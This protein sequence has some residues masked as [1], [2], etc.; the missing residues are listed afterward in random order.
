MFFDCQVD[1][2]FC[3]AF[4]GGGIIMLPQITTITNAAK[5]IVIASGMMPTDLSDNSISIILS[6]Q[7]KGNNNNENLWF[8]YFKLCSSISLLRC[9]STYAITE[10]NKIF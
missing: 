10:R 3:C 9:I 5:E 6:N 2:I 1:V 4:T 8:L 7:E